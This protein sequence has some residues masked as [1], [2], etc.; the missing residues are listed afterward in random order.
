MRRL[1]AAAAALATLAAAPLP[2]AAAAPAEPPQLDASAW[3]LIDADDG[4][5][6]ASRAPSRPLAMASA[7]KLM[8]AYLALEELPLDRKLSA[9]AYSA[10]PAESILGLRQGERA[11]V[12]DLLYSLILASANDSAVTIAEGVSGSVPRFVE[13][14]NDT[15][16]ALG[17]DDTS[18]TNPIGLDAP[19]N[20]SSARDLAA[21]AEELMERPLFRRIADSEGATIETDQR[22]IEIGTRNTLLLG[23]PTIT[24]IKTGHTLAAGYVLVGSATRD[25]VDLISVVLGAP[26]ESARDAETLELLDYGFSLYARRTPVRAGERLAS[27]ELADQDDTLPLVA[28][29]RLRVAVRNDQQVA[30]EVEAPD[31][32]I[33]PIE[34]GEKLGAVTVT[35]DGQRVGS[36]PLVTARSAEAATF[37]EKVRSRALGL[38][39]LLVGALVVILVVVLVARRRHNRALRTQEERMRRF[40]E[41]VRQRGDDQ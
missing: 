31:E 16:E 24:G 18:Y 28:E 33:G 37:T 7:T 21:L 15:A 39:M 41:R 8:T 23:D 38:P 19:G 12:R 9:P 1:C 20:R 6:L 11:S 29:R 26:S 13:E 3:L 10:L 17:L 32:V 34:R 14:M 22:T 35:V 5:R 40:E 4:E 30:T 36:V 27:P 25:D 2:P